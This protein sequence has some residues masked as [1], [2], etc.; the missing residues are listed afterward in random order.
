MPQTKHKRNRRHHFCRGE[1]RQNDPLKQKQLLSGRPSTFRIRRFPQCGKPALR[2][3]PDGIR[4]EVQAEQPGEH[5]DNDQQSVMYVIRKIAPHKRPVFDSGQFPERDVH[6][7]EENPAEQRH[8]IHAPAGR[9]QTE[10]AGGG[11]SRTT[12]PHNGKQIADAEF[13]EQPSV[14]KKNDYH[15]CEEQQRNHVLSC[16]DVFS[17]SSIVYLPH[18]I[19]Y[20]TTF[21]AVCQCS[22][23]LINILFISGFLP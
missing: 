22:D 20:Y 13:S 17:E 15:Q 6:H 23:G 14:Q 8:Q 12:E 4:Q 11:K 2:K 7:I 16:S 9:I 10:E 5:I 19:M 18:Y 1:D 21:R 3:Y